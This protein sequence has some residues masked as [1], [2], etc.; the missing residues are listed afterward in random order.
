VL[1]N[2]EHVGIDAL[3][4]IG[5]DDTLS[6]AE[7]LHREGFPVVAIPKT[8]TMTLRDRLLHRL[9][10]GSHALSQLHSQPAH[11]RGLARAHRG[12]RALRPQLRR[13][14]LISAYLAGVDAR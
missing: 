5:G 7:R 11:Q 10:H 8:W 6:Y 4:P 14:L 9:L 12:G 2:L 3:I 13:D 1:A